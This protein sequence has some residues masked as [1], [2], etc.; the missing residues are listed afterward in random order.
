MALAKNQEEEHKQILIA[1][2]TR[3]RHLFASCGLR[4]RHV[5]FMRTG[6]PKPKKGNP[7]EKKGK[8]KPKNPTAA[9]LYVE[10]GGQNLNS[11]RIWFQHFGSRVR[12]HGGIIGRLH[13]PGHPATFYDQQQ[14]Q[15]CP[16]LPSFDRLPR[17]CCV[18][19]ICE[20]NG[21][22]AKTEIETTT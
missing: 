13:T 11:S 19:I 16:V 8:A 15:Q 22:R 9:E 4:S 12:R 14:Q 17:V 21:R 6:F 20:R 18:S 2:L 3:A 1:F 10:G 5:N 7:G